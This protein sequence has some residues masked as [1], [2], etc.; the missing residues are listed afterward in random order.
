MPQP[1]STRRTSL[2]LPILLIALGF[3]F[4][5]A[6][7]RPAFD[8]WP[9]LRT[10]WPLILI[11]IGLGKIW[12]VSRQRQNPAGSRA[13]FSLG[14]TLGVLA[15]VLVLTALFWHGRAFSRDRRSSLVHLR[16]YSQTVDRQNAKSV[17]ASLETAA[18]EFTIS[19]GAT[20]L[21]DADFNYADSHETPRV[22]YNVS[23]GLGQLTVS[24]DKESTHFGR[25]QNQWDLRFSNDVPLELKLEAGAGRGRLRLRDVPVTRLD[26]S[27]GAGQV[28]LD[29][30]GDR[31]TDLVA[32]LE[33][34]VGQATIHLPKNVGVV[35]HAS[36]GIGTISAG[37]LHHDDGEYTNDAYGKT[38]ATIRL[39]IEGGVGQITLIEEP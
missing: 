38:P 2:V 15:F 3:L 5:Y 21:L 8:P 28:D 7:W 26:V 19:G 25:T 16:H 23:N 36:G 17:H 13:G 32:N 33:A 22:D 6:T 31:K 20:H 12:D 4:L 27:M 39:K 29:L 18:G 37:N 1:E 10:Y 35:V 11:F 9:I 34:G 14:S 24:Q 30:T